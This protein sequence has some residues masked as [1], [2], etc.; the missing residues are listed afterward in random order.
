MRFAKECGVRV[1]IAH[2][3]ND[4]RQIES[5]AGMARQFYAFVASRLIQ[6]YA[7]AGLGCSEDAMVALLG[8]RWRADP[9]WSVL[10]YGIDLRPFQ[11]PSDRR[12]LRASLEIGEKDYVIG[13]VGRFKPQNNHVF[14][15]QIA[16]ELVRLQP[17]VRFLLVGDGYL[18]AQIEQALAREQLA[19]SFI[20]LG[21]RPD[22]PQ[23]MQSVMDAFL[24]PSIYEGLGLVLLEAQAAGLPCVI[25]DTVPREAVVVRGL[26][27]MV[28]LKE[29]A[30]H[31]AGVLDSTMKNT[32]GLGT[33]AVDLMSSS[34]FTIAKSSATL[35]ELYLTL[36]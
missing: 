27:T 29:T 31:W 8:E 17:R 6:K 21:V 11:T 5:R 22:V 30:A 32:N 13:H 10:H 2:S 26:I 19:K 23:L 7:S 24:F 4:T 25:S 12:L 15:V 36:A 20:P 35:S 33:A 34:H 1:R 3:H 18:R 16:K 9:R 28:G 14:L